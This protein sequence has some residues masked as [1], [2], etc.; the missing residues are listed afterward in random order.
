MYISSFTPTGQHIWTTAIYD[1][2]VR[3]TVP[4]FQTNRQM[5]FNEDETEL[6]TWTQTT[7]F[8]DNYNGSCSIYFLD[9]KDGSL[10][11]DFAVQIEG[12]YFYQAVLSPDGQNV[13]ISG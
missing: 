3:Q 5:E 8:T 11:R 7:N 9:T 4:E 10:I 12:G 6:M 2:D 13:L 1:V